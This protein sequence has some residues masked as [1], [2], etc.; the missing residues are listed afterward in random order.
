MLTSN[1][2]DRKQKLTDQLRLLQPPI[3]FI[4]G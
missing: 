3:G 1:A 2:I 4:T